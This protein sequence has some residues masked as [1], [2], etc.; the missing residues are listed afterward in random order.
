MANEKNKVNVKSENKL[1]N[2][3]SA[4]IKNLTELVDVNTIIGKPFTTLDGTMI[5]PVTKV[6]MGFM[7]GGGEYGDVKILN[8]ESNYPFA[9]GGGAVISMKPAGFLI[10]KGKGEGVKLVSAPEGVYEKAFE[11]AEEFI[12][13]FINEKKK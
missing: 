13:S 10:D 11:T 1:R 8:K 4:A 6:T 2:M 3:M 5:I 12:N 9:G 7:T